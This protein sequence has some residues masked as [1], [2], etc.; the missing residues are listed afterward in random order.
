MLY[1][2]I[3]PYFW[4]SP[5]LLFV[6][7]PGGL[8]NKKVMERV[9]GMVRVSIFEKSESQQLAV[10]PQ[11]SPGPTRWLCGAVILRQ[12]CQTLAKLGYYDRRDTT[13]YTTWLWL[14]K[15]N[16]CRQ[17]VLPVY[18]SLPRS[19]CLYEI[20]WVRGWL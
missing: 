5:R 8:P 13:K 16:N 2:A 15:Q 20:I 4:C 12:W 3:L 19:I 10:V 9:G 11:H 6:T 14:C 17:R 18:P 1:M 7:K